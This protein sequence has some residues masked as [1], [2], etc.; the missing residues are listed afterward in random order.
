MPFK[1]QTPS[2]KAIKETTSKLDEIV[3]DYR[4]LSR[5]RTAYDIFYEAFDGSPVRETRRSCNLDAIRD[6]LR[7]GC[8]RIESGDPI[9]VRIIGKNI[10]EQQ[11]ECWNIWLSLFQNSD[12]GNVTTIFGEKE[13]NLGEGK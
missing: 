4:T 10:A 13:Q 12:C 5:S 7:G 11:V 1:H 6:I 2:K 8:G 9:V 3:L